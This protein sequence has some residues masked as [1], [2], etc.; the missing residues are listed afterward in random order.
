MNKVISFVS[1][2][3]SSYWYHRM[4]HKFDASWHKQHHGNGSVERSCVVES[5]ISAFLMLNGIKMYENMK[6]FKFPNA[7]RGTC[8]GYWTLVTIT[9]YLGHKFDYSNIFPVNSIQK[10]HLCHHED[11]SCN[12]SIILPFDAVFCTSK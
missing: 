4:C 5:T 2:D 1:V 9:H 3:F 10:K 6:P 12:F 11:P 7:C 8:A